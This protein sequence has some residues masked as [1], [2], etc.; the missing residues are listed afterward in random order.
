[1]SAPG[2]FVV[3]PTAVLAGETCGTPASLR[4]GIEIAEAPELNSP[5]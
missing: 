3:R 1:L 5:M 4:I 2:S